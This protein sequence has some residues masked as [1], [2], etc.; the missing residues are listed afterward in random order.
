[1]NLKNSAQVS[2][3]WAWVP[4]D[5]NLHVQ[6]NGNITGINMKDTKLISKNVTL[7]ADGQHSSVSARRLRND[8]CCIMTD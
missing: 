8:K 2:D 4:E 7:I 3:V 5:F 6:V 1:M